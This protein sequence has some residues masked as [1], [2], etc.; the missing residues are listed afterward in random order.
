MTQI[1][2]TTSIA[3]QANRLALLV[4][5][6]QDRDKLLRAVTS[7]VR[8]AMKVR[9]HQDGKDSQEGKIGTYTPA[10]MKVRTGAF[11]NAK[12]VTR[13]ANAGKFK[14]AGTFTE[15]TIRLNRQTGVFTGE[16]KVGKKRPKYNR[17]NDT[18]VIC[19]LTSQ[20]ENDFSIL[21]GD[22]SYGI[23]YNNSLNRQ[24][25]DWLEAT[26]NKAIFSTT[27]TEKQIIRDTFQAY[28]TGQL[29]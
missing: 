3:G 21:P 17:T 13:G 25:A 9:I 15:A 23:G 6:L 10:Y 20:M 24:K 8:A 19:S 29:Q 11:K 18:T 28:A 26:Y 22:T 14:D 5:Q 16:E 1:R 27:P 2:I 12:K 4:A 7:N